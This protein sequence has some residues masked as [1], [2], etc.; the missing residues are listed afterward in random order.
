VEW[1]A[2][3]K[4]LLLIPTKPSEPDDNDN[5]ITMAMKNGFTQSSLMGDQGYPNR[6]LERKKIVKNKKRV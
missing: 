2:D 1:R 3:S 6:G 4:V 5:T